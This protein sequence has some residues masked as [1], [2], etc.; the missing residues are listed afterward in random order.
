MGFCL[1]VIAKIQIYWLQSSHYIKHMT[2]LTVHIYL[3]VHFSGTEHTS[4]QLRL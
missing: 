2:F 3:L 1:P 4:Q